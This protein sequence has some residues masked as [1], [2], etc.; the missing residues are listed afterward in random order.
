MIPSSVLFKK[1]AWY[2]PLL[3]VLMP[4]LFIKK[5]AT[6]FP[7]AKKYD[8]SAYSDFNDGGSSTAS[9]SE[10]SDSSIVFDYSL[11]KSPE[12][13]GIDP[14]AGFSLIVTKQKQFLDI[15]SFDHLCVDFESKRA[16]SFVVNLKTAIEGFTDPNN[17]RSFYFETC[18]I[19]VHLGSKH[20]CLPLKNFSRPQ[21]WWKEVG[22][23]AATLPDHADNTKFLG[24]DIQ[25]GPG[26]DDSSAD[27]VVIT[28][29]SFVKEN[30]FIFALMGG[31]AVLYITAM[32]IA[33]YVLGRQRKRLEQTA[34]SYRPLEVQNHL[35][36]DADRIIRYLGEHY[37]NSEL[38]VDRLGAE[39][40]VSP[41]RIP[42]I[43]QKK[44]KRTF[45]Q[46]LN[47]I[48]ISESKRLLREVDRTIAEIAFTVGYNNVT[49]F[50]RVFRQIEG[51]S[52]T[53]YRDRGKTALKG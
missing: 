21:W 48:R 42:V 13:K 43:L 1:A 25:T 35:D 8:L 24:I 20:Y 41:V 6:L 31:L 38:T 14:Y 53:E 5:D 28:R 46:Y 7:H 15:S 16:K 40:G 49:H 17:W 29:I 32:L 10:T 37:N 52:P 18:M 11:R 34:F 51:A 2:L 27:K 44:C 39:T 9:L 26:T 47:E 33:Q 22:T 36:A 3:L 30:A 19:P 50:N 45:K 23:V 4:I 12:R